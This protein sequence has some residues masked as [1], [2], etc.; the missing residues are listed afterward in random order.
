MWLGVFG[1]GVLAAPR[2]GLAEALG[3]WHGFDIRWDTT[4]RVSLG[5]RTEAA[6]PALLAN[7]NADDGDRAFRPGLMSERV[8][9]VTEMTAQRGAFGLDV[10]AQGWY[11]AAYNTASANTSP[12]T[13]NPLASSNRGFPGDVRDLMGR[14]AEVLNAF[15]KDTVQAGDVPVTLAVG[16]QTLLWGESLLFPENGIAAAQAPV[17]EIKSLASPL[18]EARELYLPVGQIVVRAAPGGGF[19]LE[20]YD[21]F[22]WRPNRLPGVGSF[23][24]TSDILDVGGERFLAT[25]GLPALYRAA[26]TMPHGLGQFGVALRRTGGGL[27]WGVYALRADSRSPTAVFY[28]QAQRYKLDYARGLEVFGASASG[29]A[30]DANV[31]GELSVHRNTP[32]DAT[33]SAAA[34]GS[35]GA[36][37]GGGVIKGIYASPGGAARRATRPADFGTSLNGQVSVQAQVPPGWFCDGASLAAEIA[38]NV[39]AEGV[40]PARRTRF[41][42]AARAVFT[43]QYFHVLPGLD[44]SVPAGFGLGVIGRSPVDASQNAGAGFVSV[45][46][47]GVFRS[48]WQ[49]AVN[50][51]H[52]AGGGGKQ[53]LADRDFATVSVTRSF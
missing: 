17:D 50:F 12:A 20:A 34:T 4:L 7:I 40:T 6:D 19:S 52:F 29:Y 22:E 38:G 21:Q 24:S 45:G 39:L 8:D 36:G 3:V 31:A 30:G 11:D 18:A 23:F 10:S 47:I 32:L 35:L 33:T 15:M 27:D 41:A 2:C 14:Q 49:G 46:V 51:T 42:A 9:V 28:P 5:L 43:P 53:P 37:Y 16:R 26:D 44:I 13:F 1:L 48:A 25:D